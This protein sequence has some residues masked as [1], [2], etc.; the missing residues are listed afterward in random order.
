MSASSTR[1]RSRRPRVIYYVEC[2]LRTRKYLRL[3]ITLTLQPRSVSTTLSQNWFP[4]RFFVL[5]LSLL[6]TSFNAISLTIV[7]LARCRLLSLS[8]SLPFNVLKEEK[9]RSIFRST[10]LPHSDPVSLPRFDRRCLRGQTRIPS[11]CRGGDRHLDHPSHRP[12]GLQ[13]TLQSGASWRIPRAMV[14]GGQRRGRRTLKVAVLSG[15]R[16]TYSS[17]RARAYAARLYPALARTPFK[18]PPSLAALLPLLLDR[19]HSPG[20]T[21]LAA[22][23]L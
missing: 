7:P 1:I 21:L 15:N 9:S 10:G 4:R 20:E 12:I 22:P 18:D 19:I 6:S 2:T 17:Y 3:L 13:P 5:F 23:L 11:G 16:I 8:L 14:A